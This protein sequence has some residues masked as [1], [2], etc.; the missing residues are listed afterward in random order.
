M[1]GDDTPHRRFPGLLRQSTTNGMA[2]N[3]R[4]V[5]SQSSGGQES[6]VRSSGGPHSLQTLYGRKHLC[7]FH[8][9][10]LASSPWCS[11]AFGCLTPL[12]ASVTT[13]PLPLPRLCLSSYKDTNHIRVGPVMY[14]NDFI[15][16]WLYLQGPISKQ[17]HSLRHWGLGPQQ[18]F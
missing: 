15:P 17:G 9:L 14:S 13:W 3:N 12:S 8:L 16:A 7:L 2:L 5:L 6:G 18:S 10:G 11:T 1:S 4:N